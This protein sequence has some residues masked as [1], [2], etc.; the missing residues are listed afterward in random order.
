MA[1]F[2]VSPTYSPSYASVTDSDVK[3]DLARR[4]YCPDHPTIK[5]RTRSLFGKTEHTEC[6]YCH[7]ITL[8]K[9]EE[10]RNKNATDVNK[11]QELL[12]LL[13]NE[14]KEREE[15]ESKLFD[16]E[17]KLCEAKSKMS[18]LENKLKQADEQ[19]IFDKSRLQ[20]VENL[21]QLRLKEEKKKLQIAERELNIPLKAILIGESGVGKSQL[22]NRYANDEFLSVDNL[23]VGIDF[24][25]STR[26][27]NFKL[28]IWDTA[29][30][31][32]FRR[33]TA[34][35]LR[36]VDVVLICLDLSYSFDE[37]I[38]HVLTWYDIVLSHGHPRSK[39]IFVGCKYDIF[40]RK[41]FDEKILQ[42]FT[43]FA[44]ERTS[45]FIPVSAKDDIN[46]HYLFLQAINLAM[47]RWDNNGSADTFKLK[48][49]T[50]KKNRKCC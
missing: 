13:E 12:N 48:N 26:V 25:L 2:S 8:L 5:V 4:G 6:S 1:S 42:D 23:T 39:I 14:K 27:K 34:N 45:S 31:V 20:E 10:I 28:Q 16:A 9:I 22:L 29:G 37:N 46:V 41:R 21:L 33:V 7:E 11:Q 19:Q 50:M 24:K 40:I 38:K 17:S 44:E 15:V 32:A 30:Q 49:E 18:D 43:L 36:G 35:Y 47:S 3:K